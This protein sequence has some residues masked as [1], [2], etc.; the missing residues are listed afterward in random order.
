MLF[1]HDLGDHSGRWDAAGAWFAA[2]DFAAYAYDQFGHGQSEGDRGELGSLEARVADLDSF[3]EA[4]VAEAP[5][6]PLAVV[7]SG[8]GALLALRWLTEGK[9]AARAVALLGA[10]LDPDTAFRTLPSPWRRTFAWLRAAWGEAAAPDPTE[11]CRDP[12]MGREYREDPLVV[13]RVPVRTLTAI[14]QLGSAACNAALPLPVFVAHGEAD[15][16]APAWAARHFYQSLPGLGHRLRLYPR[17]RHE[18]LREPEAETV[19][20]DLLDWLEE[21]GL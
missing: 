3:V 21:R 10:P 2:R 13:A 16:L 15:P 12:R 11:L 4:I 7:G 14:R 8:L 19:M 1:L 17:L 6:L 20:Q 5:E 18:L 9:P